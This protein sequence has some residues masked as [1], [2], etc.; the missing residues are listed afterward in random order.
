MSHPNEAPRQDRTD[1]DRRGTDRRRPAD[2]RAPPPPWRRPW[3]FVAYGVAAGLAA[4]LLWGTVRGGGEEPRRNDAPLVENKAEA[5]PAPDTPVAAPRRDGPA[6]DASGAA[7][8]ERLTLEGAAAR[9][10]LVRTELYCEQPT[11]YQVKA[12][13]L[14]GEPEV[15]ALVADGRIPAA[16]C[17][18]GGA[19]DP[20][21]ESFLLLVPPA[22]AGEFAAAPV[23]SD[24]FQ[25]RR[26]VVARVE[27]L[28]RS[29]AL[30]LRTVGVF[31]GS[32]R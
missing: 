30:Q 7:G 16:D 17:K 32:A 22:Q 4:V 1:S 23:A 9:G 14:P 3:A 10:R 20:R 19:N 25:R 27:W 31:R 18:W 15:A 12:D 5:P 24:Q 28:G 21:R 26:R 2:R 11:S 29:E 8:F 6:Q 13:A